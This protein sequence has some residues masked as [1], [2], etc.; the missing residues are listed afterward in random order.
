MLY[1]VDIDGTVADISHRL[2]FIK[3]ET[4]D[5]DAFYKAA[6]NDQPIWEVISVVRA[7]FEAAHT[8]VL[9]TGRTDDIRMITI[10]WLRKYR[11]PYT[12]GIYMRKAG[13]H[14]E[15]SVVKSELA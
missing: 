7:L 8:V 13:D 10:N 4:P 11:V 5:W 6:E 3:Q 9:S 14:R 12:P 15:D 2:H 1:I